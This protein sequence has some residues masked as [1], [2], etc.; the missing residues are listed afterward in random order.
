MIVTVTPNPSIDRTLDVDRLRPAACTARSVHVHPGGKGVNVARALAAHGRRR[1][2]IVPYGGP[3]GEQLLALLAERDIDVR[4]RARRATA[5]A[6]NVTIVE[7]EGSITKINEPGPRLGPTTPRRCSRPSVGPHEQPPGSSPAGAS[8]RGSAPTST[9]A[10]SCRRARRARGSPSTRAAI[11]SLAAIA[12]Q[13]GPVK[14]NRRELEEA[15]GRV[16]ADPRGRRRAAEELRRARRPRGARQPRRRPVRCSSAAGG[17]IHAD[18]RRSRP[19][20]ARS[21]RATPCWPATS[22]A[23]AG[24]TASERRGLGVRG[25]RPARD[26]AAGTAGGGAAGRTGPRGLRQ[27][28]ALDEPAE[29]AWAW[30]QAGFRNGHHVERRAE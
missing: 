30:W 5:S 9:R 3:E 2:A 1:R 26:L 25:G 7:P 10:S 6:I 16:V 12:A 22:P 14:P 13:P 15:V 24:R 29:G 27:E 19:S 8:R 11:R 18:V 17:A 23:T 21:V 20:A 4:R 28:P